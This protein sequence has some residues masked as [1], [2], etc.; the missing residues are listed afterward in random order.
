MTLITWLVNVDNEAVFL[1]F[2]LLSI[3]VQL[4]ADGRSFRRVEGPV[5]KES[6]Q[7]WKTYKFHPTFL[8]C[9][10][11]VFFSMAFYQ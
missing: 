7:F 6:L 8:F 5:P 4:E 1:P 10:D 3:L 11:V 9:L 2:G